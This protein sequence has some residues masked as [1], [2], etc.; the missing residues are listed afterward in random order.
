M[1]TLRKKYKHF[2]TVQK[3]YTSSDRKV[4]FQSWMRFTLS[5][6][7]SWAHWFKKKQNTTLHCL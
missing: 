3:V 5:I 2:V 6:V 4:M 1:I 7:K